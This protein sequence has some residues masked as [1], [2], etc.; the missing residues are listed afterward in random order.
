MG[1]FVVNVHWADIQSAPGG[2]ITANNAIDQAITTL[3]QI[4][5]SGRIGL[6]VRLFAGIYA[7]AWAK[8]LGGPPIQI[9]DPVSGTSGTI[10]RFWTDDFGAAYNDL[11]AKLAAKYDSAPEI[12]EIT[13][14]RCTTVFVEPFIRDASN[15]VDVGAL[16]G[17]GFTVDADQRCHREQIEAHKVWTHTRSDLSFNPYQ[18]LEARPRTDEA[19]TE[20]MM[21]SCRSILGP[22]C[23]LANNSLRSPLQYAY[24][25]M[26]AYLQSLGPPIA[27]Q[28]ATL[29]RVG[30]LA[31]TIQTAISLGAASV[32]VPVGYQSLAVSALGAS[33]S[34]LVTNANR[35]GT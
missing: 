13:I 11:Q 24:A 31:A 23:V 27:F 22:R 28:T 18:S 5:S 2:P 9:E 16:M 26:Y 19:F 7:P 12:R 14:S 1:G 6:K 35:S 25:A 3:H 30:N 10:G 21:L 17:A 8:S 20:E 33:Y 32:E 29:A 4:D 34:E 15:P